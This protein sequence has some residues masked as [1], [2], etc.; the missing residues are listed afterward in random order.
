MTTPPVVEPEKREFFRLRFPPIERPSLI[1][2]DRQ[3]EVLDC[4]ARGVRFV[5]TRQPPPPSLGEQV[6]GQLLFR[7]NSRAPIRG[8]IVRIQDDEIALYLPD[9]EIP[10][11]ILRG[12]ERYLL[13]HYRLWAK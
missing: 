9:R 1:V 8:L 3:Y 12:E 4:S 13:N 7:R 10:F 6:E 5:I 11:T 2:G